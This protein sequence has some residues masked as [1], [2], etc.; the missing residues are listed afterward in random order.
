MQLRIDEVFK[1]TSLSQQAIYN[2]GKNGT[3]PKRFYIDKRHV[4]W[5]SDEIEEWMKNPI[6]EKHTRWVA[7]F[8]QD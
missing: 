4:R 3:F 6:V 8:R 7:P 1:I 5:D 2:K